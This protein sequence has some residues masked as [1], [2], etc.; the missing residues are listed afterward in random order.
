MCRT[1]ADMDNTTTSAQAL[2]SLTLEA[3]A[4]WSFESSDDG[5]RVH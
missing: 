1:M 3:L 4:L 5:V 2:H